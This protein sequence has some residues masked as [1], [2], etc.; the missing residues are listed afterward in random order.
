ML[1]GVQVIFGILL[2]IFNKGTLDLFSLVMNSMGFSDANDEFIRQIVARL[3]VIFNLFLTMTGAFMPN[4]ILYVQK[5]DL[6]LEW[7][8]INQSSTAFQ[9]LLQID[10][11]FT[12]HV[13]SAVFSLASFFVFMA[14]NVHHEL[15]N[16]LLWKFVE[17]F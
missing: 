14:F 4:F 12:L 2:I 17:Y 1:G 9:K 10:W 15:I 11:N 6:D 3:W 13:I 8:S 16:V 7:E 5:T